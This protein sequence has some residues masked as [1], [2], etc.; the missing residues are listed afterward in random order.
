MRFEKPHL[1][2]DA[3][4]VMTLYGSGRMREILKSLPVEIAVSNYVLGQEALYTYIGPE[5]APR[6]SQAPI[7]LKSVIEEGLINAVSM[8][9]G[10]ETNRFIQLTRHLDDGEA[11]TVAIAV[12]R[13]WD[14]ATDDKKAVSICEKMQC[15]SATTPDLIRHWAERSSI[16]KKETGEVL[17]AVRA[18]AVY[19]PGKSHPLYDWWQQRFES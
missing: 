18:R 13:D 17:R 3:C 5:N 6:S 2:L 4:C 1:I 11:R 14:V 7:D 9:Q 10:E 12:S 8:R 16:G 19:A 15:F